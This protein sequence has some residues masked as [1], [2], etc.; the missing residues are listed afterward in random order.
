MCNTA[1]L[2]YLNYGAEYIIH[3]DASDH[4]IGATL[5]QEDAEGH[6]RLLCCCSRKINA[7]ECNY[8]T[9][10]REMLALVDCLKRWHHY[11]GGSKIIAYTDNAALKYWNTIGQLSP[12]LL[13]WKTTSAEFD[14]EIRHIPAVTNTAADALSRLNLLLPI[15]P[16]EEDS[17]RQHYIEDPSTFAAYFVAETNKP[18]ATET[19]A[20][21]ATWK[22]R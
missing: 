18:K 19:H 4:A 15:I 11:L 17:W 21:N 7:A 3:L 10:K 1:E 14:L 13:R 8:P 6:L 20:E 16:A 9:H 12:R 22:A 2:A 5:S